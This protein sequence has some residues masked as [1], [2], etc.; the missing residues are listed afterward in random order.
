[1]CFH[2]GHVGYATVRVEGLIINSLLGRVLSTEEVPNKIGCH[3]YPTVCLLRL[4]LVA[5]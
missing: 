2:V 1:M 3:V 5:V 4:S